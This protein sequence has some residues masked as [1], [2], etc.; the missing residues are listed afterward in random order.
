MATSALMLQAVELGLVAHPIAG[1][2]PE[3]VKEVLGI[4]EEN[5]VITL[6]IVGKKS[7]DLSG[8]AGHQ[9]ESEKARPERRDLD[10]IFS[11]DK[12]ENKLGEEH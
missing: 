8:L 6:V 7:D 4:P 1:Y 10:K 3:K 2:S 9:L 11:L 5:M 12:Y